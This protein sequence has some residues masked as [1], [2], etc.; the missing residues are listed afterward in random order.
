MQPQAELAGDAIGF[1]DDRGGMLA[2]LR[3]GAGL[4]GGHLR[5]AADEVERIARLVR[6]PGGGEVQFLEVGVQ[7][8]GFHEADLQLGVA[9]HVA[10]GE[11]RNDG[12][13]QREQTDQR[14]QHEVGPHCA[15]HLIGRKRDDDRMDAL[16]L[17][18]SIELVLRHP[19]G[20]AVR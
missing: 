5:V 9:R 7:L 16:L 15:R 13:A 19:T 18:Q 12:A 17:D 2:Q 20:T 4:Q 11:R 1:L 3:R 6:E 10:P 8:A 14:A